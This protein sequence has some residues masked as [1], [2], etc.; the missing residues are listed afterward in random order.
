MIRFLEPAEQE[1]DDAREY[2]NDQAPNLGDAFVLEIISTLRR[3]ELYPDAWMEI[4]A[5][6]RRCRLNRFPYGIIYSQDNDEILVL[7][8]AHLH[9]K[10]DYWIERLEG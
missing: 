8:I 7:A 6:I 3:I 4:A 1:L 10:P 9:R 5:D 2:Y